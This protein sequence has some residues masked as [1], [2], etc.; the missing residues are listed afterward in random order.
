MTE[1]RTPDIPENYLPDDL[2]VPQF[3]LDHRHPTRPV[4]TNISPWLI[5]EV[6]GK[7]VS[8]EEVRVCC[9]DHNLSVITRVISFKA[10]N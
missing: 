1:F 2:T 7:G 3:I 9:V 6:S 8:Y 10:P 4:H 5:E